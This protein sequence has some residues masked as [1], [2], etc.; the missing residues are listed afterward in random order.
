MIA[1]FDATNSVVRPAIQSQLIKR[2]EGGRLQVWKK[3]ERYQEERRSTRN[4]E[5]INITNGVIKVDKQFNISGTGNIINVADYM[6]NVTNTVNN[7]LSDSNADDEVKKL[8]NQLATEIEIIANKIDPSQLKKLGKN[9]EALSV[10][11]GSDEP[12]RSWYEVSIKGLTDA[13][14]AIGKISEPIINIVK[15]LSP[16]LLA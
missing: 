6:E 12:D 1:A 8:I 9:L 15:K 14:K 3:I 2:Y 5:V 4:V 7:N 11:A 16:L 10:E 13:A